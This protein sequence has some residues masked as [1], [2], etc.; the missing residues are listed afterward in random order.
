MRVVGYIRVST[1]GQAKEGVSIDA[2]QVEVSRFCDRERL[3]PIL[4]PLVDEGISGK[5]LDRPAVKRLLELIE[6]RLVDGVVF[7]RLDRLSRD[8][9]DLHTIR[10]LCEK[11]KVRIFS[12]SGGEYGNDD[13]GFVR[14]SVDAMMAEYVR[15][16]I[17]RNTKSALEYKKSQGERTGGV[18]YG[19]RVTGYRCDVEGR[20]HAQLGPVEHE[21]AVLRT[22]LSLRSSGLGARRIAHYLNEQGV[23]PKLGQKWH[24]SSVQSVLKTSAT[25]PTPEAP[26]AATM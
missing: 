4:A 8:A 21:Q 22:I 24:P 5:T 10:K 18:P 19:W 3:T 23:K 11:R 26:C 13:G 2:Q 7:W 20:Q 16:T 17:S 14:Y 25:M 9:G 15:R 6:A 12:T 1:E